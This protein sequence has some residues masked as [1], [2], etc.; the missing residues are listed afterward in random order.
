MCRYPAPGFVEVTVP[1]SLP[2][3]AFF[4]LRSVHDVL[5]Y[6]TH[7][8]LE[9]CRGAAQR[10]CETL[11][12]DANETATPVRDQEKHDTSIDKAEEGTMS[13]GSAAVDVPL[14]NDVE[15]GALVDVAA[16]TDVV[17][18][19]A[20]TVIPGVTRDSGLSS[21]MKD[22][23]FKVRDTT[24]NSDATLAAPTPTADE[25][26]VV[27]GDAVRGGSDRAQLRVVPERPPDV[28][29]EDVYARLSELIAL[30]AG[31]VPSLLTARSFRVTCSHAGR[32]AFTSKEIEFE[33]GVCVLLA[34]C[35]RGV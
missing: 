27:D 31:L 25:T 4:V 9:S 5:V 12:L 1:T 34:Q 28:T 3:E 18:G 21:V 30:N 23:R 35:V 11:P 22:T 16:V 26:P 14:T 29:A 13:S 32:H 2:N 8:T 20:R 6:H 19:E 33:A 15:R 7:L 24:A 17:T 10:R